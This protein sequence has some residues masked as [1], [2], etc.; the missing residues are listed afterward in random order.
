MGLQKFGGPIFM[1][2]PPPPPFDPN[3]PDPKPGPRGYPYF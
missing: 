3:A 1:L 2:P